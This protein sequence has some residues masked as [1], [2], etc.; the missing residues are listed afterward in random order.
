MDELFLDWLNCLGFYKCTKYSNGLI[1]NKT[2]FF[3]KSLNFIFLTFWI[4]ELKEIFTNHTH[5]ERV[6]KAW[7]NLSLHTNG[8][9]KNRQGRSI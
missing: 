3:Y 4:I 9:K 6:T 1:L 5:L 2:F 7:V 8:E